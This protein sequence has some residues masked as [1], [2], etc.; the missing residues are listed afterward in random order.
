[1]PSRNHY[2]TLAKQVRDDL[3]S[4]HLAFR[5]YPRREI[6][7]K[8]RKISGEPTTRIKQA[9]MAKEIEDVF[10]DQGL[11]VYPRLSE[12]ETNDDV[13]VWRAGTLAAEVLDLILYPG[14]GSDR[15]LAGITQKVKGKW[16]WITPYPPEVI[17]SIQGG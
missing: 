10:R 5:S 4:K 11:R 12:T 15:E 3:D 14:E 9:G 6:T 1:M 17:G 7:E 13:R 16:E 2:L 8:L